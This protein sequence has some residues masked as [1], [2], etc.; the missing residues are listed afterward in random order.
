MA[1]V[2]YRP[3]EIRDLKKLP[4]RSI[5]ELQWILSEGLYVQ[6]YSAD[7]RR[8]VDVQCAPLL[9]A[10]NDCVVL[11]EACQMDLVT[12][13]SVLDEVESAR[14]EGSTYAKAYVAHRISESYWLQKAQRI[15]S[16]A[17]EG[18]GT[19]EALRYLLA[20]LKLRDVLY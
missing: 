17:P 2:Q 11:A 4:V 19:R 5:S 7:G 8:S 13:G 15:V 6:L 12:L 9:E 20:T 1:V 10:L 14:R 16:L 18:S 3:R